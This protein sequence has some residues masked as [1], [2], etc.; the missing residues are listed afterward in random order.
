MDLK[1]GLGL[2]EGGAANPPTMGP[3]Y[4]YSWAV[5][6]GRAPALDADGGAFWNPGNS[7]TTENFPFLLRADQDS[8]ITSGDAGGI[9]CEPNAGTSPGS[10]KIGFP[11]ATNTTILDELKYFKPHASHSG[12]PAAAVSALYPY[13]T[14][15]L[16]HHTTT[17]NDGRTAAI[18]RNSLEIGHG[19]E[20]VVSYDKLG[21]TSSFHPEYIDGVKTTAWGNVTAGGYAG[22]VHPHGTESV[23]DAP[24]CHTWDMSRTAGGTSNWVDMVLAGTFD[25]NEF[26]HH[27]RSGGVYSITYHGIII[28]AT[29]PGPPSF[30]IHTT[31]PAV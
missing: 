12:I 16:T 28:S 20:G 11:Y 25:I 9:R 19:G 23:R 4:V 24:S 3:S 22:G 8:T 2:S 27:P 18:N 7:S 26:T 10:M 1:L 6:F 21:G 30:P 13:F 15:V 31:R 17:L 14:I 29:P 5:D